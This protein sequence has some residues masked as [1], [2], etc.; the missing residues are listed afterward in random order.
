MFS[1]ISNPAGGSFVKTERINYEPIGY[2]RTEHTDPEQTPIQPV[3]ATGHRGRVELR[4][5]YADGLKDLAGFSHL[6]LIYHFHRAGPPKLR[7]KPFLQDV[8]RGVFA[9]RAPCRPNPIGLSIVRLRGIEGNVLLIDDVDVL[10]GTPI[11]DIK[12]YVARFDCITGTRD[13]WHDEVDPATATRL[14]RRHPS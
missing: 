12:P 10:D 13:G 8:K 14:G 9:T 3:Y 11:L 1:S 6:Y 2:V 4:A 7:V 5:A